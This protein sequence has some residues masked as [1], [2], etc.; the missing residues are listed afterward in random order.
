MSRRKECTLL[1]VY[2]G[3]QQLGALEA[4]DVHGASRS[5][6]AWVGKIEDEEIDLPNLKAVAAWARERGFEIDRR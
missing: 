3:G 2:I 1:H 5:N 6:K 4:I